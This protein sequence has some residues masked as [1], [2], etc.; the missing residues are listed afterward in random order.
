MAKSN[1]VRVDFSDVE[2]FGLIPKGKYPAKVVKAEINTNSNG[3]DQLVITF[4]I[5]KGELKGKKITNFFVLVDQARFKLKEFMEACGMKADGKVMI[6]SDKFIGKV[7]DISVYIDDYNDQE[8]SRISGYM[9]SGKS[10]AKVEDEDDE[11]EEDDDYDEDQD[12]DEEEEPPVK[13]TKKVPAKKAA[14]KK[15]KKPFVEDDDDE[16]EDFDEDDDEDDEPTPPKK[17][18]K[19]APAKKA[20]AKKS[21]K[22][23]EPEDDDEDDDDDEDWED[24]DED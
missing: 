10:K 1:K 21:K 9:P 12:D 23:P 18:K 4:Q 5:T 15:V 6:D 22:R 19:N 7:C 13:K 24:D 8:R 16:D 3:N 17:T 2:S 11:E 20:P 14:P